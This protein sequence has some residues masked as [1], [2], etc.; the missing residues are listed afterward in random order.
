MD[1]LDIGR[2]WAGNG[3]SCSAKKHW[4]CGVKVEAGTAGVFTRGMIEED[5][6][7]LNEYCGQRNRRVIKLYCMCIQQRLFLMYLT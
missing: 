1:T 2:G 5:L 6:A 7:T 4:R 3:K